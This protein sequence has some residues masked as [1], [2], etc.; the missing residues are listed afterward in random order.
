MESR[1]NYGDGSLPI[2]CNTHTTHRETTNLIQI[3]HVILAHDREGK[4][5]GGK[6]ESRVG[7]DK[8]GGTEGKVGEERGE[9]RGE[10]RRDTMVVGERGEWGRE[11]RV[12]EESGDWGRAT[13]VGRE[14]EESGEGR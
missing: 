9:E 6:R 5:E 14:R 13:R 7:R 8:G 10:W 3:R 2:Y 1:E 11:T 12:G 4:D